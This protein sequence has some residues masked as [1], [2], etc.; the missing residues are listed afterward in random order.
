MNIVR[1]LHTS[2]KYPTSIIVKGANILGVEIARSLLEQGGFVIIID[3]ESNASRKLLDPLITYKNLLVLDFGS[4]ADL[5]QD[6]R[7][8]DY[9]FYF[10][11]KSTE[12]V[13]KISTQKFLQNS[14]YLD[15]MLDLSAKFD[16]KFLLTTA[17]RA[18][19]L[20]ISNAQL[21]YNYGLNN[22]SSHTEYI[23]LEIQ[24]YAESLV[25]EYREKVGINSRVLRL[26]E[27]IGRG[28]EFGQSSTL[29]KLIREGLEGRDLIVPGDGLEANYYIHYLDAAYGILKAQ[30]SASSK[31]KIFT[32]ANPE[33]ITALSV[34]YKLLELLPSAREIKFDSDDDKFPPLILYK[35]AENLAVIGWKPRIGFDRALVQTIE[36]IQELL[37]IEKALRKGST[38]DLYDK[39]NMTE[40]IRDFFFVAENETKETDAVAKL[41]AERKK[42]EMTRT[43]S[44][45]GANTKIKQ[46]G[47]S[48]KKMNIIEKADV[49]LHDLLFGFSRRISFLKNVT[50][51]DFVVTMFLISG[52][53]V[54][55]FMLI[56]P[57]FSLSRNIFFVKSYLDK[58]ET[59]VAGYN[60]QEAQEINQRLINNL[61][62]AQERVEDLQYIFILTRQDQL[63]VD[64]QRFLESMIEY[65]QAYN[66]IFTAYSPFQSYIKRFEPNLI[67]RFGESKLL[68]ADGSGDYRTEL[69][70]LYMQ[71]GKVDDSLSRI[72]QANQEAELFAQKLP[73]RFVGNLTKQKSRL[74]KNFNEFIFIADNYY[75]WPTLF[76][77]EKPV[78]YLVVVQDNTRY[79]MSGG[80][81]VG[82]IAFTLDE[83]VLRNVETEVIGTPQFDKTVVT[84]E[85]ISAINLVSSKDVNQDNIEFYDL[86]AISDSNLFLETIKKNY[87]LTK[88][89]KVDMILTTNTTTLSRYLQVGGEI[90]FQ[91]INFNEDNLLNSVALLSDS[92]N[93]KSRNEV[94][95][96][97]YAKNITEKFN[98]LDVRLMELVEVMGLAG[99]NK[100][101]SFFSSNTELESF[102]RSLGVAS[103]VPVADIRFGMIAQPKPEDRISRYPINTLEGKIKINADYTTEKSLRLRLN[104][105]D[106]LQ[107]AV[108]C[109]NGGVKNPR[110]FDVEPEL[111]STT[112]SADSV[113]N[114]FLRN[115]TLSYGLNYET[116]AFANSETQRAVYVLR[117]VKTPGI[118]SNYDLEFSFGGGLSVSPEDKNFVQVDDKYVYSGI[119]H[120]DKLFKFDL[121]K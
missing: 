96:N 100:E 38:V 108:L 72:S 63:Y 22:R 51:T 16:A 86:S 114:I 77:R 21:E 85:I 32:L 112:F 40:K 7:R 35:P 6:L 42:L 24:R 89:T 60:F 39:K 33:E 55:Y 18:H 23:E 59:S 81:I 91:Q 105:A 116:I 67:Y 26:G 97:L 12:L 95:M 15:S 68:T 56:S 10:E 69:D 45:V 62:S 117:L 118:E 34:A 88:E 82:Y 107:N 4:I 3:S 113:C 53:V 46:Q 104:S 49:F 64:T 41:I 47:R 5:S 76:G 74:D 120:N 25:Q 66:D 111:V 30:F 13:E 119:L 57:L 73:G 9:I 121:S 20:N 27:I 58:I 8:L 29:V 90:N 19:Q 101:M 78:T 92:D 109:V 61:N 31:G 115:K 70:A 106:N 79:S 44:M 93:G 14:N 11:H 83:G 102:V 1:K 17:I 80:A 43:G 50:I 2:V 98:N 37:I 48:R 94:L 28:T 87:E 84:P 36:Y 110:N 103:V 52:F 75:Y 99:E 65:S 71:R 54:I